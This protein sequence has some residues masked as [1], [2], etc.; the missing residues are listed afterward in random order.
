MEDNDSCICIFEEEKQ[1]KLAYLRDHVYDTYTESI[2]DLLPIISNH[3]AFDDKINHDK[4]I[5]I[6]HLSICGDS[7][8]MRHCC[9]CKQFLF[10]EKSK[11]Q[12]RG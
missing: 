12:R 2:A 3:I 5:S 7:Y 1:I 11:I 8:E 9:R 10:V 6:F 4:V